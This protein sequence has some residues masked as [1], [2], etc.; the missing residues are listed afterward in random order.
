[1]ND[2]LR[3]VD[4]GGTEFERLLLTTAAEEA[5]SSEISARMLAGV[6]T[7]GAAVA[8]LSGVQL[9][10]EGAVASGAAHGAMQ[11][12]FHAAAA[13]TGGSI[14]PSA[15]AGLAGTWLIKWGVIGALAVGGA[16]SGFQLLNADAGPPAES[17]S[18]APA[19]LQAALPAAPAGPSQV[20][21]A[22]APAEGSPTALVGPVRAPEDAPARPAFAQR[23]PQGGPPAQAL[24]PEI[25]LLD[26]A[27]RALTAGDA[28][29]A[30]ALIASYHRRFPS[31]A[32][33]QE[34]TVLEVDALA[35]KGRAEQATDLKQQFLAEHPDSAHTQRVQRSG[36][37]R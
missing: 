34:A 2:P 23:T 16:V 36:Q 7:A 6:A 24:G 22:A 5:P 4:A 37:A 3:L 30:L 29:R 31:G 9:A 17:G 35:A 21:P 28:E 25:D 15:A 20:V 27:R 12:G 18:A 11:A 33:G 26:S 8:L 10:G 1:M 13:G 19:A 32:L 14:A